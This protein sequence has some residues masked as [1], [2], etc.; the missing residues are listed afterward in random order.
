MKRTIIGL[1]LVAMLHAQSYEQLL[2]QAIHNNLTLQLSQQQI[3]QSKLEGEISTR[4]KNPN[5]EFEV[6]DFSAK[7]LLRQNTLGARTGISQELMLPWVKEDKKRLAQSQVNVSNLNHTVQKL[8]FIYAFNSHYSLYK[9]AV[10]KEILAQEAVAIASTVLNIAQKRFTV[11]S[12]AN[13]ELL[14]AKIE[15]QNAQA[16]KETLAIERTKAKNRLLLYA[17][18]DNTTQ[19]DEGHVFLLS[20]STKLHPLLKLSQEKENVAQA[21]LEVASHSIEN[22]ELFS[23]IEA[24]PDQDIFRIGVSVPLPIFNN[25]S[26]EKQLAK[27]KLSSQKL[28]FSTQERALKLELEQ[29]QNEILLEAQMKSSYEQLLSEQEQLLGMYEQGYKIA[30]VNLLKLNILKKE[31]LSNKEQI[32]ER[33]FMIE[34]KN[35]KISYLQG[36]YNE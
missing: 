5:I 10:Q 33:Q 12:I 34:Q 17:N 20:T 1:S 18:L 14:Q 9:K 24:E 30:K 16:Q 2:E 28:A 15:K 32:L 7:R 27:L 31:L 29:L 25:K 36:A 3:E 19:I 11:G 22:I 26:Q 4:L 6:A 8:A 13:S 21:E 23:E 35:I